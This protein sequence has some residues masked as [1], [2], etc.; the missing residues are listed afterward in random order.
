[1]LLSSLFEKFSRLMQQFKWLSV[2]LTSMKPRVQTLCHKKKKKKKNFPEKRRTQLEILLP[3]MN[4]LRVFPG[5]MPF[6]SKL[7]STVK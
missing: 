4:F 6:K 2:C 7:K 1:M 3:I 5:H